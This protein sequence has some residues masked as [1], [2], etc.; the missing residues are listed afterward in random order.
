MTFRILATLAL[1]VAP[2][3][4]QTATFTAIIEPATQPSICQEE[5]HLVACNGALLKSTTLD[6]NQYVGKPYR[7][8]AKLGGVTCNVW[9]VTAV[10]GAPATLTFC[11]SAAPGCPIRLRVGPSGVIGMWFLWWSPSSAFVPLDATLGT[12]MLGAPAY[13]LGSGPTATAT[14]YFETVLPSSPALVG[15]TVFAQGARMDIGP[16]GPL[17]LTNP[18]CF[19][20]APFMPPCATPGC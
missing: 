10:A 4:A 16:V 3:L 9:N 20:I 7:F 17:Q 5:T 8:T 15:L 13:S 12:L 1:F 19:T 11:G 14:P 18:T 6:L 2:A